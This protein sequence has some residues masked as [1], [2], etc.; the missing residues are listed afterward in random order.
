M[1][2]RLARVNI[3]LNNPLF[4]H[5]KSFYACKIWIGLGFKFWEALKKGFL[6]ASF[7]KPQYGRFICFRPFNLI[8]QA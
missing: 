3:F 5:F 1:K 8:V 7:C 2:I 6:E 4:G